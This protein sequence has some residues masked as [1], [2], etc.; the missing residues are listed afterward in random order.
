MYTKENRIVVTLDAG[1]TNFVFSAIQGNEYVVRPIT[2]PSNAS[3]LDN[4]LATLV[5]GF[6]AIIKSLGNSP[7]AISFAFPGPA[8]YKNGIIGGYLPNFPSF[9]D[10]VA[11]GPFLEEKFGLPVYIN[12]DADLFTYG[13]AVAGALPEINQRLREAGSH[14]QYN[15]LIGYTWGTGFGYGLSINGKLH[16]GDNSCTETFCLKHK[17]LPGIIVEDGVSVRAIKRAYGE[18]AN[19]PDYNL[20]PVDIYRVATGAMDG[21]KDAAVKAFELFGEIAGDAIATATSLVDGIVVVGGGITAASK[22]I[23]PSMLKEMRSELKTIGGESV[24]RLQMNVYNLDSKEEFEKFA[25]GESREISVYGSDKKVIYD[26]EKRT[27]VMIS[28]LGASKAIAIGAYC[29][30]IDSIDSK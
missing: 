17:L 13:E 21:D 1:G 12:N 22:F 6:E 24:G 23:M 27:G 26:P 7:V 8:D 5:K 28:K 2:L 3:D 15:N 29:Y 14:K 4:C 10:G 19:H 30:A 11:L 9:R 18:F 16:M 20:E 25:K